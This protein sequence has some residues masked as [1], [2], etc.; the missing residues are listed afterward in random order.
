MIQNW[1]GQVCQYKSDE[2]ANDLQGL[3][4]EYADGNQNAVNAEKFIGRIEREMTKFA[5]IQRFYL[6]I[7]KI[8]EEKKKSKEGRDDLEDMHEF[9]ISKGLNSETNLMDIGTFKEM[10]RDMDLIGS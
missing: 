8:I 9:M 10:L 5:M 7:I 4:Q 1:Y 2:E 3:M 6:R